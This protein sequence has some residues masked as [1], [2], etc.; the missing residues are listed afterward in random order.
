M[1]TLYKSDET[2]SQSPKPY[3]RKQE[4][5]TRIPPKAKPI[6]SE[7]MVNGVAIPEADILAEAQNHPADNPGEA[8]LQAARALVV[9]ELLW[10]EAERL[11]L[12]ASDD[13]TSS[14]I[15]EL[16]VDIAIRRLM[17]QEMNVPQATAEDCQRYYDQNTSRFTSEMIAEARHILVAANPKDRSAREAAESFAKEIIAD[18]KENPSRFADA[19]REY[20]ACPSAAQ[21]GN[22]GQLTH[23]STVA[24]FENALKAAEMTGLI[25]TP[26]ETRYGYHIIDI[27]RKIPGEILPFSAVQGKIA[28]WLEAQSWSRAVSQYITLLAGKAKIEG[29]EVLPSDGPLVQ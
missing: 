17:E 23:G 24:E 22:L 6:F 11:G 1:V 18:L 4:V 25:P 9:R 15:S 20:S 3:T 13:D 27:V 21:G 28:A 29:I 14:A 7:V 8:L 10:Q 12:A 26:V 19:A 16:P 5:D 2:D